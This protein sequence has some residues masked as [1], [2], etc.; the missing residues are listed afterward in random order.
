MCRTGADTTFKSKERIGTRKKFL[1]K[2]KEFTHLREKLGQRQR[3][4]P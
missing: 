2:E 4:L 3:D 1:L